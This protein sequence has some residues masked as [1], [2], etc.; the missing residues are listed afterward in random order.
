[1]NQKK[2]YCNLVKKETRSWLTCAET[3]LTTEWAA[4]VN[5]S[6]ARYAPRR[7]MHIRFA[8]KRETRHWR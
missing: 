2:I 8:G 4:A 1:M 3:V 7:N 5:E 6:P